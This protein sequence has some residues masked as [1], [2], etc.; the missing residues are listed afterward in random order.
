MWSR[1]LDPVPKEVLSRHPQLLLLGGMSHYGLGNNEK[2]S[3]YL[4]I[5]VKLNPKQPGPSKLLASIYIDRGDATR[6]LGVARSPAG[7][8]T[9]RS[10]AVFAAGRSEHGATAVRRGSL[11]SSNGRSRFPGH[12]GPSRRLRVSLLGSGQAEL[13][14]NQL[15]QA[16]AKDPG[17]AHAGIVLATL[18]LRRDQPKKALEVIDA[19]VR[20]APKRRRR[21]TCRASCAWRPATGPEAVPPTKAALALDPKYHAARLNLARLDIAEGKADAARARLDGN[22]QDR[23]KTGS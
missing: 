17:Q 5:Y 7:G 12:A 23:P 1:M 20:R 8:C 13:G 18:Y 22:A 21:S 4:A 11:L 2:A 14:F 3:L 6:A 9:Q 10:A 15:Q 19:V 16:F